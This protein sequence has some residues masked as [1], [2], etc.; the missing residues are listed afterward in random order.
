MDAYQ[1]SMS[2]RGGFA[3]VR[4]GSNSVWASD[5]K[6]VM[7]PLA[8]LGF[9]LIV[10]LCGDILSAK[11]CAFEKQELV[12]T[13]QMI[14]KLFSSRSPRWSD[15]VAAGADGKLVNEDMSSELRAQEI[16]LVCP[17]AGSETRKIATD[18][19]SKY[20]KSFTVDSWRCSADLPLAPFMGV[21]AERK[22]SAGFGPL[23]ELPATV[24]V[25]RYQDAEGTIAY[26]VDAVLKCASVQ[27]LQEDGSYRLSAGSVADGCYPLSEAF[28]AIAVLDRKSEAGTVHDCS[29]RDAAVSSVFFMGWMFGHPAAVGEFSHIDYA[30]PLQKAGLAAVGFQPKV[31]AHA[32]L[33]E[34]RCDGKSILSPPKASSSLTSYITAATAGAVMLLVLFSFAWAFKSGKLDFDKLVATLFSE[35]VCLVADIL[36]NLGDIISFTVCFSNLVLLREELVDLIPICILF[37]ALGW[38]STLHNLRLT[39]RHFQHIIIQKNEKHHNLFIQKHAEAAANASL[40]RSNSIF[41]SF[42]TKVKPEEDQVDEEQK[43]V[44]LK[45]LSEAFSLIRSNSAEVRKQS[46]LDVIDTLQRARER[47][48]ADLFLIMFEAFPT[49]CISLAISLSLTNGISMLSI[50]SLILSTSVFGAKSS[51][52]GSYPTVVADLRRE[53]ERLHADVIQKVLLE[54]HSSGDLVEQFNDEEVMKVLVTPE[55]NAALRQGWNGAP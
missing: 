51:G 49:M 4:T 5:R 24:K 47:L 14:A 8:G 43:E 6:T 10:N 54:V 18:I 27:T 32:K 46:H 52:L 17:E 3:I 31:E 53:Q 37:I 29:S 44:V 35:E 30:A 48:R 19:L 42:S 41:S 45:K 38:I 25:A 34:L 11:S 50:V 28:N 1:D 12:V 9:G 13:G 55:S 39:V 15:L 23:N 36:I 16:F 40:R 2:V 21:L 33:E 20:D 22:L 7:I 26:S